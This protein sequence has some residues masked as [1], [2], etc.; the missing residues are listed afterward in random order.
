M[1]SEIQKNRFRQSWLSQKP[2]VQRGDDG[3]TDCL[4]ER[5]RRD[6]LPEAD[7]ALGASE[8]EKIVAAVD[9]AAAQFDNATGLPMTLYAVELIGE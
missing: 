6:L 4:V 2:C 5:Y 9:L 3:T 1:K 7:A 8:I